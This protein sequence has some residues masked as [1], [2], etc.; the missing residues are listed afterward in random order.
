MAESPFSDRIAFAL[1]LLETGLP[2]CPPE[3][4]RDSD[5]VHFEQSDLRSPVCPRIIAKYGHFLRISVEEEPTFSALQTAWRSGKDSNPSL[6][7]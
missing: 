5:P 2:M 4:S 1:S 6:Q 7:V 3:K